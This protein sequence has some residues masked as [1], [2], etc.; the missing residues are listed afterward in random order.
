MSEAPNISARL[1]ALRR[2]MAESRLDAFI[3][4]SQDPHQ[5]EYVA[6]H[7]KARAWL[8]GFTGS[9]GV[10]VVTA[11]HAG[12]WT[13]SRYFIQAEQELKAALSCCIR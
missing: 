1:S 10:A 9:A 3:I 13:D 12:L 6:E 8:S 4:P 7:W 5:S 11:D 2:E